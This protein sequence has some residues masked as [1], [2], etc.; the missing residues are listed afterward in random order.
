[1]LVE[2]LS[3]Q[4]YHEGEFAALRK[5]DGEVYELITRE[6]ERVQNTLQ[7]LAA[8]N[9]CSQ[10]VLAALGSVVQNKTA[11]GFA[12]ARLHGGCEVVDEIE[13]LAVSRAKEA[14]GA[15][16]ANVQP[17]SGTGANQIVITALL[18]KGDRSARRTHQTKGRQAADKILSLG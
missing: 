9:R 2:G 12:G 4:E 16:Y 11:E 14:F 1:M 17:H 15:Q 7:L 10:A 6:Y 13:R 18:E 5:A 3:S 8:E